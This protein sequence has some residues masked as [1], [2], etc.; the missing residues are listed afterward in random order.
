MICAR[1]SAARPTGQRWY[2]GEAVVEV[3]SIGRVG[4]AEHAAGPREE[5]PPY[6]VFVDGEG[7]DI[8]TEPEVACA[9][10]DETHSVR[11]LGAEQSN[12]SLVF[13]DELLVKVFRRVVDGPN[14][15]VEVPAALAA[16][17]ARSGPHP[18][19]HP[20]VA[21]TRA[22]CRDPVPPRRGR[23]TDRLQERSRPLRLCGELG[24]V[25]ADLHIAVA[26]R[27][28]TAEATPE[29]WAAAAAPRRSTPASRSPNRT[30][31]GAGAAHSRPRGPPP[32]TGAAGWRSL[33][34]GRLRGRAT[35]AARGP[36]SSGFAAEG[37]R[38]HVA[39]VRL[40]PRARGATTTL[41]AVSSGQLRRRLPGNP[42]V[43][44]LLPDPIEPVLDLHV[45]EKALY[46]LRYERAYR[47]EWAWIPEEALSRMREHAQRDDHSRGPV[48][49]IRTRSSGTTTASCA[50][51]VLARRQWRR[52]CPTASA[53]RWPKPS[54]AS[55][56]ADSTTTTATARSPTELKRRGRGASN[57]SR[58]T[59]TDSGRRSASSIFTSPARA[60]TGSFGTSS[61]P[62]PAFTT[63]SPAPRSQCG[64]RTPS[65]CGW[66][67]TGISGTVV[68]TRCA[69]SGR[70]AS[71]SCSCPR[72][73]PVTGTSLRCTEPTGRLC[74]GPIRWRNGRR[75]RPAQR[76][77]SSLPPSYEW[78]DADWLARRAETDWLSA[79]MSVYEVHL[80]SWR[81]V[82]DDGNRSMTL[83]R[84][85]RDV[86]CVLRRD[87][88]HPRRAVAAGGAS[89]MAP[90]WG[91]Q[92]TVVLRADITVRHAGRLPLWST[93]CTRRT[94]A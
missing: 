94:S 71:G 72:S 68:V 89:R 3:E 91:Y 64:P 23:W 92:V 24:R 12:T 14:P 21:R 27:L 50:S 84:A 30:A 83:P 42:G 13:D 87:G 45:A 66:L 40:R 2:A 63:E 58:T 28:P 51:G 11:P 85:R 37:R 80:G 78:N 57:S 17:P 8:L 75:C 9:F 39:L 26:R 32:R 82:P 44:D 46:E 79:P 29:A 43:K 74:N 62:T 35:A 33:V 6:Q 25:L 1:D 93:P 86:A 54:P 34:G 73:V 56:R 18:P 7:R 70:A 60:A 69:R 38:R 59:A 20:A 48:A 19:L 47:P 65:R 41:G 36:A 5:G 88:L 76:A 55:S 90:S 81:R 31:P 53:W 4:P 10:V 67:V 15:D 52:F 61:V 77:G 49:P 16:E 22:R